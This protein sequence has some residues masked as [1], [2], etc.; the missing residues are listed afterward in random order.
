MGVTQRTKNA[1]FLTWFLLVPVGMW[2]TFHAFPPHITDQWL[3]IISFIILTS[4]VASNPLVINNTPI[5][6]IQWV[7]LASFLYFGLFVEM[8]I[9]QV[10]FVVVLLKLRIQKDQFFRY[11]LNSIMFFMVS[12]ISG[13]VYYFL[14]GKIGHNLLQD[15]RSLWIAVLYTGLSYFVNQLLVSLSHTFIYKMKGSLF[16]KD[17]ILETITTLITLPIGFVLYILNSEVGSLSLLYVGIP[18][19]SLSIILHLYYSSEKINENLQKAAEIGHQ[20]AEH[21]RV[22]DVTDLFIEKLM[23]MLP[24]DY[25]FIFS[26]FDEKELRVTRRIEDGKVMPNDL[27]PFKKNEGMVGLVWAERKPYLFKVRKEWRTIVVG[28]TPSDAESM[29]CVPIVRSDQVVGVLLLASKRKR[30]YEKSQLMIVDIL[31]SS[32]AVSIENARHYE[33]TKKIS[34]RCPLT[35]LYN[36]RFF[37]NMLTNEYEKLHHFEQNWLSLIILDIDHFKSINDTFGHQSGNE[38][39]CE[40]AGRIIQK[41][42]NHGTAARYGGEEFVILMPNASKEEAFQM[43]EQIRQ[44]IADKPFSVTQ[45]ISGDKQKRQIKVTASIGVATAPEDASDSLALIRRAD[46]ALYVGAKQAG[47]NRVAEYTPV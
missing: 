29:L 27:S 9:A 47:R 13:Y 15:S 3:T 32:F 33:E 38:I 11:P 18:F 12:L 24:V 14:G 30:A 41:V 46:R 8:V 22:N 1:I 34:E 44:T 10:A 6:L 19:A 42:G 5:F 7:S 2:L 36:Y 21:L 25:A 45:N 39:L 17:F 28:Y 40:L 37:E 23:E 43:A 4:V 31:C 20:M 26:I 16:G 35:N